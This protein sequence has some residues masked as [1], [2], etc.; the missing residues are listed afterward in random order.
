MIDKPEYGSHY[1]DLD[2]GCDYFEVETAT[3]IGKIKVCHVV[4][5]D[6]TKISEALTKNV[7]DTSWMTSL[8]V[9]SQRAY[10]R[11]VQETASAL[12]RIFESTAITSDVGSEFGEVMV[13]IGS[14]KALEKIFKHFILPIAELWKPQKKQNEGFDFH[15]VCSGEF[16]N[17]GE[18]KYSGSINPHGNAINQSKEFIEQEKHL[19]DYVHLRE[20]VSATSVENLNNDS[21]G[22]I[23]SFSINTE[24]PF[25]ILKKAIESAQE[26]LSSDSIK[27]VYLVGV[28]K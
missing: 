12:V 1:S 6:I 7:L 14:T 11:T 27:A 25:K 23:A 21:Y 28:S 10:D 20:L 22:V 8:D 24:D 18:A 3:S 19:R 5:N 15:T 17:F 26:K 2:W 16:I 4:V 13:S 9:G